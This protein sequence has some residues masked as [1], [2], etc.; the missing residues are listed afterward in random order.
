MFN[1]AQL[2]HKVGARYIGQPV[3]I[4]GVSIDS[5]TLKKGEIFVA[6][7]GQRDGHKFI[8]NAI[9]K[10]AAAV[11]VERDMKCKIPQLIVKN[12]HTALLELAR[13]WRE[14]FQLPVVAIT[15]SYGKTTTKN[16]TAAILSEMGPTL[17]SPGNY[18]NQY[19]VPISLLQLTSAHRYA[20]FELG[21]DHSGEIELLTNLVQPT[22]S[23]VT[24]VGDVHIEGFGSRDAVA[25]EKG[26]IYQGLQ[27]QGI[28]V[29]NHDEPYAVQWES[30]IDQRH[31]V[32]FA[33]ENEADI[34]AE[35]YHSGP[36]G[37]SFDLITPIGR[38]AIAVPLLGDFVLPNAL[39]A[40]AIGLAVGATLEQ[41]ALGLSKVKP[42][43]GRFVPHRLKNG[44][45]VID[46]TYNANHVAAN[47]AIEYLHKLKGKRIFVMSNITELG[48]L[49]EQYHRELGECASKYPIDHFFV[50]GD[51]SLLQPTLDACDYA[52]YFQDKSE[53]VEAL[54]PLITKDTTIIIKGAR[55]NKMEE[56]LQAVLNEVGEIRQHDMA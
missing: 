1:L 39:A 50:T 49:S 38:Q 9:E 34:T 18:N 37:A 47:Q 55:V 10:G 3:P 29:I 5:R 27:K 19:G 12:T 46:D 31:R 23:L 17:A 51:E 13:V 53:L 20:V 32:S 7:R 42:Y 44:A 48:E 21:T 45:M 52:R 40:A 2:G 6:I 25:K 22:V 54:K 16:M 33:L 15:G 43:E 11:I 8:N 30:A 28:A 36:D 24:R 41:V 14:Q 56:I 26:M 35:H 4:H